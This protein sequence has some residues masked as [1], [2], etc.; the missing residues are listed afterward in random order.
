MINQGIARTKIILCQYD[1]SKFVGFSAE[2][3]LGLEGDNPL[4]GNPM[5][6]LY[7]CS[8]CRLVFLELAEN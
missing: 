6:P 2:E 8:R 1:L 7:K 5:L 4:D 3:M